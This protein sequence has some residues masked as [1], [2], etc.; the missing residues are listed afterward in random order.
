MIR[1]TL[2]RTSVIATSTFA[3]IGVVF[4]SEIAET[5]A[6]VLANRL[7]V[8]WRSLTWVGIGLNI[9]PAFI[10]GFGIFYAVTRAILMQHAGPIPSHVVRAL[11]LYLA[12]AL[13]LFDLLGPHGRGFGLVAQ[14]FLWPAIAVAGAILGDLVASA[15]FHARPS[16]GAA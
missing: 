15:R 2:T 3:L 12:L 11:P 8:D 10:T 7:P 14:L 5:A 13:L 16:A 9:I 1:A 4:A 6:L